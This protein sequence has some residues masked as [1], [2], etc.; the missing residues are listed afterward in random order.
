MMNLRTYRAGMA[1]GIAFPILLFI[2]VNLLLSSGPDS[3][4]TDSSS[5]IAAKWVAAVNDDGKRLSM[6]IGSFI[7]MLAALSLIWFAAALRERLAGPGSP[8]FGFALLAAAGIAGSMVG[9]LGVVGG[10]TFGRQALTSNGDVIRSVTDMAFPLLL[11]VFGMAGAAFIAATCVALR[12]AGWP[13][14]LVYFGWVAAVAGLFGVLF[15]PLIVMLVWFLAA[16]IVGFTQAAPR[17]V[18]A[19]A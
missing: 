14:W 12:S 9:H 1:A 6:I 2:G 19:T 13:S 17:A 18:E 10:F 15:M 8:M 16:G 4:A 5:A 3:A 7:L 11:V